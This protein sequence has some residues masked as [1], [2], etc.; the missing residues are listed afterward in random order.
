MANL[1]SDL[2][3]YL[4]QN[5]TRRSYKISLPFSTPSFFSRSN[6]ETPTSTSSAGTWYD[7]V[8]KEYFTLTRTQRFIGFAVC[9]FFGVLCFILSF[10][11]I[12]LLLLQARKFALLFTLGSLFFIFSF[13][14]LWGPW[15]HLK[16]LFS[17]DKALSTTLYG[18]TLL[19]TLYCALHLQSTP[20]TIVCAVAQVIALMWMM[21]GSIPGG[22]S[23]MRF[24]G[25]M[26][27]SSVSS[28]LPI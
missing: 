23:G 16:S 3:Q 26:F 8:Q 27:K 5:E 17:K 12:P 6:E 7:E 18:S 9:M 4:L 10:L 22:S 28:T 2:D 24:F 1:K 19:A 13:S 20:L 15:A 25:S 21:M 14:F 11:Y